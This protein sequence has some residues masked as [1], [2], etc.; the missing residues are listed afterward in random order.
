MQLYYDSIYL[1]P[2][3]DDAA[4]SCGGQIFA[5]TAVGQSVLIVT[6]MAGSP[7]PGRLSDFAGSLHK[8]WELAADVIAARRREDIAACNILGAD[9]QH[10]TIPD[11]IYRRHPETGKP[12]YPTW[13]DV[14]RAIHPAEQPLVGQLARQ[15]ACLPD[16]ARMIAPLAAGN[17]VDHQLARQAAELA[18]PS[19]LF[20]YEDYPYVRDANSLAAAIAPG[21]SDWQA[22]VVPLRAADIAGKAAA[23]AAFASQVSTFFNGRSDLEQQINNYAR[24]VGGERLWTRQL[25]A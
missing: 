15:I 11:C 14:I 25:G 9:H 12:L 10:W 1:S 6:I 13:N 22:Q 23:V 8:R 3:P 18:A 20:Y 16:H 4:L 24:Q 7:P 19:G 5:A 2:H 21:A 17:H